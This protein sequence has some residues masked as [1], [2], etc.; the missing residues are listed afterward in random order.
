[1]VVEPGRKRPRGRYQHIH[2]DDIIMDLKEMGWE[3]V[4]WINLAQ[5]RDQWRT[6]MNMIMN[7]WVP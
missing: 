6:I 4:D 7:H 1:L 5:I 3:F 2:V